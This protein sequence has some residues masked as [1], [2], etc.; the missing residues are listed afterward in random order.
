MLDVSRRGLKIDMKCQSPRTCSCGWRCRIQ[1][2]RRMGKQWMAQ[3]SWSCFPIDFFF[4]HGFPL[5]GV[6][7]THDHPCH[8][9]C[10]E[11]NQLGLLIE[12]AQ[13]KTVLKFMCKQ[14]LHVVACGRV[15]KVTLKSFAFWVKDYG[16]GCLE[17]QQGLDSC[18]TI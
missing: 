13:P 4:R 16:V 18:K 11:I 6:L 7:N 5:V 12:A 2:I 17:N 10:G 14:A 1:K 15:N 9:G 3:Q 8:H